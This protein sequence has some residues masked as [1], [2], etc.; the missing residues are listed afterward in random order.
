MYIFKKKTLFSAL[1]LIIGVAMF[2]TQAVAQEKGEVELSGQVVD[3]S[4]QEAVS[5][6]QVTLQGKDKEATT[7]ED[8]SFTFESLSSGTYTVTVTAEG[9]QDWE[10][11]VEVT[12]QGGTVQVELE[13]SSD[14]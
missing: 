4:T 6:A 11:D 2:S 3:A 10:Q 12:E 5:G 8:G 14:L 7:G 9:Y 1:I 13:P